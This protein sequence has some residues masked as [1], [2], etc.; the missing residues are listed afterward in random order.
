[1][2]MGLYPWLDHTNIHTSSFH[3]GDDGPAS[4]STHAI[5]AYSGWLETEYMWWGDV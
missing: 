5:Y 3:D 1:M 2:W 4:A